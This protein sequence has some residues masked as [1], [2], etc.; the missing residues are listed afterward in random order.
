MT[1]MEV[2]EDWMAS[3]G[4][5]TVNMPSGDREE[6][7][8]SLLAVGGRLHEGGKGRK[9]VSAFSHRGQIKDNTS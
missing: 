4:A 2:D 8:F 1:G 7:T 9:C 5:S 6:V 3:R